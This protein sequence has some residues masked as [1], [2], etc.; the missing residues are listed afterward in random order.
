MKELLWKELREHR[1]W[2]PLPGLVILLVF[3][4]DRPE[5]PMFDTTAAYFFCLIAVA[6][7]AALGFVQVYFEGH[8]DKRSLLLHR[9]LSATRIFLV[10]AFVGVGLYLPALGVP[11]VCL[12]SWLAAPG[13]IPAPFHWQTSFPWLADILS[14]LVYYFAGMLVAQREARWYGSRCLA[15]AAAFL[16]SYL[17]W[18]LAEFSEA[19]GVIAIFGSL[20][21]LVAW[22]SFLT[23]G[24]YSSQPRVAKAALALTLLAGLLSLGM[25]GKQLIGAF[26]NSEIIYA[27]DVERHGRLL[28][29]P[30]RE[31]AGPVGHW[32]DLSNGQEPPDL[33]DSVVDLR[34]TTAWAIMERPTYQSYRNSGRFYIECSNE[35]KPGREVWYFDQSS[36]RLLGYDGFRHQSLGSFGPDGFAPPGQPSLSRFPGELRHRTFRWQAV[37]LDLLAFPG[38]VYRVDFVRRTLRVIVTADR[39]ETVLFAGWWADELS[40][41]PKLAVVSTDKRFHVLREDGTRLVSIPRV[42]DCKEQVPV[43]GLL[44]NPERYFVWYPT[45]PWELL[46][47]PEAYQTTPF[48]FHEYDATGSELRRRSPQVPYT[49]TPYAKALFGLATPPTEAAALV[50]TSRYLRWE[51]RAQG[52]THKSI[53]L[54]FLDGIRHYVPGTSRY[55]EAS[56]GVISLYLS[57]MVLSA[58]ASALGCLVLARRYAF[59]RGG[60]IGWTLMGFLFGWAG[61]VLLLVFREWPALVPCPHCC[62]LRIASREQCEHCGALHATPVPDG[63]EIVEATATESVYTPEMCEHRDAI[64]L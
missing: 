62:K 33:R 38:A 8:G 18:A 32:I 20:T 37:P 43:I 31:G 63:T 10:K 48:H 23:G 51:A 11:F 41:R 52:S 4:L 5:V 34:R 19:L 64:A 26:C 14:G 50:G 40:T 35:T 44:E 13:N 17:V 3:V 12:E 9:P 29:A 24:V 56:D 16:C 47:E 1:K 55:E 15:L 39:D 53:L 61:F 30:T 58:T 59:S 57:L 49:S 46:I 7:G 60:R 22:G 25:F 2:L 28:T 54:S 6:F 42:H 27:C 21:A 45:L 36:G